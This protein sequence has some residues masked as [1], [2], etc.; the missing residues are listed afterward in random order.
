MYL[1]TI[2]VGYGTSEYIVAALITREVPGDFFDHHSISGGGRV[3]SGGRFT[4]ALKDFR[5][6][7]LLAYLDP[8]RNR[9]RYTLCPSSHRCLTLSLLKLDVRLVCLNLFE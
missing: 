6:G 5:P 1:H 9:F 8:Y 2:I 4:N 7:L 3:T